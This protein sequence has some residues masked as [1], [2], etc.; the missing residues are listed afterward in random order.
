M[1][2][3]SNHTEQTAS[4][5]PKSLTKVFDIVLH[6]VTFNSQIMNLIAVI[7]A[8]SRYLFGLGSSDSAVAPSVGAYTVKVFQVRIK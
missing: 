3:A 2:R 6:A 4:A 5:G 1:W 8:T 7:C